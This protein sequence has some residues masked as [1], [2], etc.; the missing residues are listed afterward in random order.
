MRRIRNKD[1]HL[2]TGSRNCMCVTLHLI[3]F[4]CQVFLF[5]FIFETP[6]FGLGGR[7]WVRIKMHTDPKWQMLPLKK[8]STWMHY[9][10]VEKAIQIKDIVGSLCC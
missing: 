8:V 3:L 10:K 2:V 9:C 7:M 5:F 6:E 1:S 4:F